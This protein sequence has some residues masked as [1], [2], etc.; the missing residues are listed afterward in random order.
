MGSF[1]Y[2]TQ[3]GVLTGHSVATVDF[4]WSPLL[5]SVSARRFDAVLHKRKNLPMTARK[6]RGSLK[7]Q[8]NQRLTWM[9][10]SL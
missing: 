10:L 8:H 9:S 7:A 6:E 3:T 5:I 1:Y 4:N 2:W